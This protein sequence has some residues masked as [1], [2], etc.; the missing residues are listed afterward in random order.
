MKHKIITISILTG[1]MGQFM[2]IP[3]KV[4]TVFGVMCTPPL[5]I[6]C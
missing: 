5:V 6:D 2:S 1:S 3:D 4:Y